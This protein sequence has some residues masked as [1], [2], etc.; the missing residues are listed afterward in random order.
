MKGWLKRE[1]IST[2][3]DVNLWPIWMRRE[4]RVEESFQIL[5]TYVLENWSE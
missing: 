4:C 2:Y 1:M 3:H 5:K